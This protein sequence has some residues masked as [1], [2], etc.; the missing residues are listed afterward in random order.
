MPV[1]CTIGTW[2]LWSVEPTEP[3]LQQLIVGFTFHQTPH[4]TDVFHQTI[5]HHALVHR[6]NAY[7]HPYQAPDL[8]QYVGPDADTYTVTHALK[9]AIHS[10]SEAQNAI[11]HLPRDERLALLSTILAEHHLPNHWLYNFLSDT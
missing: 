7:F 2:D 10:L 8:I 9:T 11:Q 5:H 3:Q 1:L 6:I 4:S